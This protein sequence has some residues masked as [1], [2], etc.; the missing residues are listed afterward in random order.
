MEVPPIEPLPGEDDSRAAGPVTFS[1]GE[2]VADRYRIVRF[3]GQGGMGEVYE[4]DDLE[5]RLRLALK[6][7]RP[8]IARDQQAIERFKREI[9]IARK[10]THP[11]VCRI[12]DL[13]HHR[14]APSGHEIIFLT[15][16]LLLGETL[17]ERVRRTGRMSTAEAL[18]LA[19]QITAGLAAAHAAGIVHRDLKAD[20]IIL[21][22]SQEGQQTPR[23]RVTDFGLAYAGAAPD[24]ITDLST[25]IEG[26]AGTPAYMAPEQVEGGKV[27]AASDIY[28][29]GI[30]LKSRGKRAV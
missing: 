19:G 7:V 12:F 27:T 14:R 16:E 6:T 5:L 28:S 4:A 30:V 24:R 13:G 15:M 22:L 26:V 20:N 17:A 11:N 8:E 9:R 29:L 1:T 23:A 25:A 10:V 21:V 2:L 18:P 3:I